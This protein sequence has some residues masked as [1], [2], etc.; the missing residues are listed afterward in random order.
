VSFM[1]V[2]AYLGALL[3]IP[4]IN[5]SFLLPDLPGI[6]ADAAPGSLVSLLL[7]AA[8]AALTWLIVGVPLMRL[9]GLAAAIATLSL[10][11]IVGNVVSN[12]DEVTGGVNSL[13]GIPAY[14]G[15]WTTFLVVAVVL[16][17]GLVFQ[18]SR[19]GRRLRASREDLVA[20]QAAGVDE[21]RDRL[22]AFVLS[23]AITGAGGALYA[24]QVGSI[25]A[26]AF[27]FDI[28]FLLIA[29]LVVGGINSL[30]GAVVGTVA[31]SVIIECVSRL[32]EGGIL[33]EGWSRVILAVAV[34]VILALKPRGITS[35]RDPRL[36][37][38]RE[39]AP[40]PAA[41]PAREPVQATT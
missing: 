20:A 6:L 38:R 28:T 18:R 24:Q 12:W 40:P 41:G 23:A 25:G 35:G 11:V 27:G 1:A 8:L 19:T 26:N 39:A 34:V 21:F 3:T 7:A 10:L 37:W 17:V 29:M 22:V 30:T 4:V 13:T 32:E 16:A 14:A 15:T 36:P 33:A 5:K 2:G 9:S 31:V